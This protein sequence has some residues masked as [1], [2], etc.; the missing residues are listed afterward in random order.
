[1]DRKER[2]RLEHEIN[3]GV[4]NVGIRKVEEGALERENRSPLVKGGAV[5][6]SIGGA[7]G[8]AYLQNTSIFN[9]SPLGLFLDDYV[10]VGLLIIAVGTF[11]G[12][13]L[14]WMVKEG[15]FGKPPKD[16]RPEQS[17]SSKGTTSVLK[18]D[19]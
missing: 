10:L 6:F 5:G 11:I 4:P 1:M 14:A 16:T 19:Q 12:A 17:L 8:V 9:R 13:G 18:R 3:R 2:K 7:A 15:S